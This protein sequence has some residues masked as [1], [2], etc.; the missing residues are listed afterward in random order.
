MKKTEMNT[1]RDRLVEM[2]RRLARDESQLREEALSGVGGDASGSLSDVPIHL[3]DLGSH[4]FEE[5]MT[6]SLLGSEER[7]VEEIN[8]ACSRIDRGTFGRCE[9]CK[10]QISKARLH[11]VPYARYCVACAAKQNAAAT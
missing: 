8:A 5:E 7:L 3:A 6:L 2:L 11:A 10:R 4:E 1:Y 9:D